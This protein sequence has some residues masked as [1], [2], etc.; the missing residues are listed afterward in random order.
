MQSNFE[1]LKFTDKGARDRAF[2]LRKASFDSFNEP[3]VIKYSVPEPVMLSEE[4]FKLD[5]KGRVVYKTAYFLAY[6]KDIHGH[7]K[8]R[9]AEK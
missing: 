6:P 5:E 7:R 9:E 2:E 3:Q 1:T 4:E 8:R